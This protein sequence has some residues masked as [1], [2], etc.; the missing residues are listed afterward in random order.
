M[1]DWIMV[2]ITVVYVIATIFIC[3]ANI[4]SAKASKEQLEDSKIQFE[5][6]KKQFE[7]S[8]LQAEETERVKIMPYLIVENIDVGDRNGHQIFKI[9][10]KNGGNG[11]AVD[12][13]VKFKD[14]DYSLIVCKSFMTY[15]LTS[16]F[17]KS[18][19]QV[20]ELNAFEVARSEKNEVQNI[21]DRV[22]I[23]LK[24]SD[25]LG[26]LYEQSLFFEYQND[27]I[28]RIEQFTPK[29]IIKDE[30]N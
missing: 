28:G 24:F 4:A 12:L 1:T 27:N 8:K 17:E 6:S 22:T 7:E 21:A 30:G 5:E 20:N 23:K 29:L 10:V 14:I 2:I 15:L 25:M 13:S 11:A 26:H 16:P 18:Y 9:L 19:L 3:K